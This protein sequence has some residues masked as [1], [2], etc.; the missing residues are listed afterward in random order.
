VANLL[1]ERVPSSPLVPIP[2]VLSR[3]AR[4]GIDPAREIAHRLAERKGLP[5]VE[6]LGARLHVVRRAGGDHSRSGPAF[7]LEQ[8][9]K[10]PVVLVDDVLTTGATL[11]SAARTVGIERVV[12]AVTANAVAEMSSLSI[13]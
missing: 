8:P 3:R 7:F 5:V 9:V 12:G 4:Y 2:R 6:S 1:A 11:I 10:S 13:R